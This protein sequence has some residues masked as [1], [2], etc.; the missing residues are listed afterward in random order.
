V[1]HLGQPELDRAI[2]GARKLESRQNGTFVWVRV[3]ST[4]NISPLYA[5][6]LAVHGFQM[7]Y[8]GADYNVLDSIAPALGQC[9]L[10][11]AYPI[12]GQRIIH[13]PLCPLKDGWT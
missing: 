12:G 9:P 4:V 6:T 2:A 13:S 10:C 1:R 5:A 8:D 7:H 3:G 11:S